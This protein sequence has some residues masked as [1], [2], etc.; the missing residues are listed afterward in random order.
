[1]TNDIAY[2]IGIGIIGVGH[3]LPA[4]VETNEALCQGLE[5]SPEWIVEKTGIQRRYIAAPDEHASGFALQAARQAL[6]MAGIEGADL[7]III[8]CTFSGDYIFPPLSAKLHHELGC[9][10]AQV[11]DLQ[12]NCA[13]VVAGL[14]AASD[15]MRLDKDVRYALIVGVELCSRY[16]DRK[17]VNTAIYLSD[18]AGAI[19]LG[20]CEAEHGIRTSAFFTDSSNYESVR[21][22]GGGSSFPLRGRSFDPSIDSMDMNGLATW[23]QAIT[24]LPS[25]IRRCCEKAGVAPKEV[26]FLVFHQANLRLIEYIVRKMGLGMDRTFTNVQEIG[27]TGSASIAIALS[28]AVQRGLIRPD[29]WV[30]LAGVGAGFNFGASLWRWLPRPLGTPT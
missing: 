1:M 7:D 23:K 2:G 19:V 10:G 14:T 9:K 4:H 8:G 24:H 17:D 28:E 11:Y 12:A 16:V 15:R 13:G 29:S 18:G 25:V 21:M 22:R 26:D 27:N 30:V 5:V 20:R 6:A 3:H